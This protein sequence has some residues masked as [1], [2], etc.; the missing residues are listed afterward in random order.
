MERP[1]YG[2]QHAWREG[3]GVKNRLRNRHGAAEMGEWTT[4]WKPT[5]GA[6]SSPAPHC[7]TA[8]TVPPPP[9]P[10]SASGCLQRAMVS[11]RRAVEPSVGS[12]RSAICRGRTVWDRSLGKR[13]TARG[14]CAKVAQAAASPWHLSSQATPSAHGPP[15]HLRVPQLRPG[16]Q[17]AQLDAAAQAQPR[18]D[19]K[20]AWADRGGEMAGYEPRR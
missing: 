19:A 3:W 15:T 17:G 2:Q 10:G 8:C 4:A 13:H 7:P 5:A 20:V 1:H 9:A 6:D 12:T 11:M 14:V 16:A 18:G